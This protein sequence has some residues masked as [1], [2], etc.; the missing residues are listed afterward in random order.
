MSSPIS[1]PSFLQQGD[2]VT[3]ISTSGA[4]REFDALEKGNRT[5]EMMTNIRGNHVIKQVLVL[6][7][8]VQR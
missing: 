7:N 4:L 5:L 3:V 8:P 6:L 1:F 2:L